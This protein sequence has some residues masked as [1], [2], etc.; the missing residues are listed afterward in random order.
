MRHC[1]WV[2]GKTVTA[3]SMAAETAPQR[4]VNCQYSK[5][6]HAMHSTEQRSCVLYMCVASASGND[7]GRTRYERR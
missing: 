3:C 6:A 5:G 1:S 7:D 2:R 4:Q